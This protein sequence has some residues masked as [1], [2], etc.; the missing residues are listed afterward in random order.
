MEE[1]TNQGTNSGSG[2]IL[3]IERDAREEM[4]NNVRLDD[5][6]EQVTADPA[7]VAVNGCQGTLDVGPALGVVVVDIR[8]VVV[9][10]SDSN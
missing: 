5:V 7:K 3:L 10:V 2:L 8:V 6:V 4:V 1:L 9:Q